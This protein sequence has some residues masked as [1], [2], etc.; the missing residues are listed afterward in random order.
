LRY[1]VIAI[2]AAAALAVG[3]IHIQQYLLRYRA[4]RLLSDIRGLD[5]RVSTFADAQKIFQRWEK[6]G[7][8]EG[9]CTEKRCRFEVGLNDFVFNHLE[10]FG[11]RH[12]LRRAYSVVGG[13]P[14]R[15]A[16]EVTVLDGI[17][18]G[19]N[20]G[21]AV[22]VPPAGVQN[23]PFD[24]YG[25]MLLGDSRTVSR[26][27]GSSSWAPL[28]LH[29]NYEVSPPGGCSGCM[30]IFVRF[31]PYT[32]LSDVRRLTDFN[33]D[34]LTRW[35]PCREQGDLMPAA[36]AEYLGERDK[37][38]AAWQG[39]HQCTA[40]EVQRLGR[41]TEHAA[42]VEIVRNQNER[43]GNRMFQ[44]S[45]MRLVRQL[46]RTRFWQPETTRQARVFK[47]NVTFTENNEPA[48]L[49][50][51]RLF[52]ILFDHHEWNEV[53]NAEIDLN[54]CGVMPAS[55]ENLSRVSQGVVQDFLAAHPEEE[56]PNPQ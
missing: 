9:A 21:L 36:W 39:R 5:L 37:V 26:F 24:G 32:D 22:Y 7:H 29:T 31:T 52:I 11:D 34:C 10:I 54:E 16:A 14:T 12:W 23:E 45:T 44:V 4:E 35:K 13:R 1:I 46:K 53:N 49:V 8:Y 3:A 6:W 40:Q 20:F 27:A 28:S 50:P 18:W 33:L 55:D 19:K 38:E 30:A 25:Y 43:D 47:E 41:D 42:L 15:I 51:G 48:D 56:Q 17:A 2:F